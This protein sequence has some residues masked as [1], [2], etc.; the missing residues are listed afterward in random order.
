MA[1][2]Y[3]IACG[4]T[5]G[6]LDEFFQS[7]VPGRI[8]SMMDLML[9]LTGICLGIIVVSIVREKIKKQKKCI[10]ICKTRAVQ[11]FGVKGKMIYFLKNSDS[12]RKA[13]GNGGYGE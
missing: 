6:G 8:V 2:V 1:F 9:Y 12:R 13:N 5:V 3:I 4:M 7:F 11:I 10:K